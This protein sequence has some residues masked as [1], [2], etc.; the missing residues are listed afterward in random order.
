MENIN[1]EETS[2]KLLRIFK[3]SVI[4]I[5]V[6]IISLIILA[7]IL[8]YTNLKE[9]T[10]KPVIIIISAI[11]ILIGSSITTLRMKKNGLISGALIGAIYIMIIYI[12]SSIMNANFSLNISSIIMLICS[13]LAGML[14]GIIGINLK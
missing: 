4:S 12:F 11:S 10:I 8:T 9:D 1:N 5:V 2:K 3:G 13:I 6:T 14:G 7:A